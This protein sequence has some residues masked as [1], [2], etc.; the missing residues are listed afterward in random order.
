MKF[1]SYL[2]KHSGS[3]AW[4]ATSKGYAWL[5][6]SFREFSDCLSTW[7]SVIGAIEE[8]RSTACQDRGA[9]FNYEIQKVSGSVLGCFQKCMD[10]CQKY[11]DILPLW[12]ML[13]MTLETVEHLKFFSYVYT[14]G[15][16]KYF[17]LCIFCLYAI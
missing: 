3:L 15:H 6:G 16:C 1:I 17:F 2:L 7:N 8:K 4:E 5:W 13:K 9:V 12:N 10:F 14:H 11:L